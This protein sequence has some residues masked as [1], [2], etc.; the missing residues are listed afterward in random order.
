MKAEA[1]LDKL[2]SLL[3]RGGDGDVVDEGRNS[4]S[5][6][7]R[8]IIAYEY[9][10]FL[11][12]WV[13]LTRFPQEQLD[14]AWEKHGN[15]LS[16]FASCLL[17][18]IDNDIDIV[19]DNHA[20]S[21]NGGDNLLYTF[22]IRLVA[23]VT[24]RLTTPPSKDLRR[25]LYT[26]W[27][28]MSTIMVLRDV[29]VISSAAKLP[30]STIIALNADVYNAFIA[31]MDHDIAFFSSDVVMKDIWNAHI[32]AH[33][34][35]E[36]PAPVLEE[37]NGENQKENTSIGAQ[38]KIQ[39]DD[40][41]VML[42]VLESLLGRPSNAEKIGADEGGGD[43]YTIDNVQKLIFVIFELH[44]TKCASEELL[45]SILLW[46][47]RNTQVEMFN[48]DLRILWDGWLMKNIGD[49]ISEKKN[50]TTLLRDP[51]K[52]D[53]IQKITLA[54]AVSPN[55]LA[56]RPIAWQTISQ[57]IMTYGWSW[58]Q[59]SS[60]K[61]SICTWCRLACGEWKIQLEEEGN[62]LSERPNRLTILDGCGRMIIS[63]VQYLVEFGERPDKKIP[64]G[65]ESLLSIRQA[66]EETLSLTSTYLNTSPCVNDDIES[67]IIINLWSELFSE[68]DLSTSKEAK[69]M[70]ACLRKLLLVSSDESLVQAVMYVISNHHTD[71]NV[72]SELEDF[73]NAVMEATIVY[74]ERLWKNFARQD[75]L[76]KW[77]A[78]DIVRSACVATEILAE[79]LPERI[80]QVA[81]AIFD[82]VG[83]LVESF[84]IAPTNQRIV[85][86]QSLR[87]VIDSCVKLLELFGDTLPTSNKSY[88][89]SS[90]IKILEEK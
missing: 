19:V 46:N 25:K 20:M 3:I 4:I 68:I 37:E 86:S 12:A 83:F 44:G 5:P 41:I 34:T 54:H 13:L 9:E 74:I 61:T 89:I 77:Y 67:A 28:R 21:K 81:N 2:D 36:Q 40:R 33:I 59:K 15:E 78:H 29:A 52:M 80:L 14:R 49:C 42:N 70:I 62:L 16:Y 73:E 47:S 23:Q 75:S 64:L 85:L 38:S 57:I 82:A 30:N 17:N 76:T 60:I 32:A 6:S 90:A 39:N 24:A 31:W 55:V 87:L 45:S 71:E 51:E 50:D 10:R 84:T 26:S 18:N 53:A 7:P 35:I 65:A 66:L 58:I 63:I 8:Q 88:I 27:K 11:A 22:Y 56:L 72:L 69:S 43:M 48:V 1:L 79:I